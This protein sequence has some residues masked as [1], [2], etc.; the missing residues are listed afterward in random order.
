M[1]VGMCLCWCSDMGWKK[2]VNKDS[3]EAVRDLAISKGINI[4]GVDSHT[5]FSL[6]RRVRDPPVAFGH[7]D[8]IQEGGLYSRTYHYKVS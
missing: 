3:G 6:V 4:Y 7:I 8:S 5:L 2:A 1:N